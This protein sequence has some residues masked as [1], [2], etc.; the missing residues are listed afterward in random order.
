VVGLQ[1]APPPTFWLEAGAGAG[2]GP[3]V[4]RAPHAPTSW[5]AGRNQLFPLL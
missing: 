2:A 3:V 4:A 1:D 5:L